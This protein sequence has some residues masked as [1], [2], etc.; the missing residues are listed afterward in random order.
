MKKKIIITFAILSFL[1]PLFSIAQIPSD[2]LSIWL[3]SDSG[4]V[5]NNSNVLQWNDQSGNGRNAISTLGYPQFVANEICGNPVIRFDGSSHGMTTP[6][7]ETFSDKRGCIF[8]VGK[9]NGAGNGAAGYGTFVSTWVGSGVAWQF[10]SNINTYSWYDGVGGSVTPITA[11]PPNELGIITLNRRYDDTLLFYKSGVLVQKKII[12]NNQPTINEVKI[13]YSGSFEV[14][15][16]DIAEIIIYNK[17]LSDSEVYQVNTYL[18]NK[19]CL[20]GNIPQ[21][22]ANNQSNCGPSS[23]DLTASGATHYKWYSDLLSTVPIDTNA[24][25]TTPLLTVSDTFYVAN[26]N[27]TLESMRIMVIATIHPLPEVAFSLDPNTICL[28][29]EAFTLTGGTPIGGT[30][31]GVGVIADTF[32]PSIASVGVHDIIY[33]FTD[34]YDCTNS[35]TTQIHINICNDLE[36]VQYNQPLILYPNPT[37]NQLTIETELNTK[38]KFDIVNIMGQIVYT[39]TIEKTTTIDL[40]QFPNG[41]Y[42]VKIESEKLNIVQKFI[43]Q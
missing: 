7:F 15:N 11:S 42:M 19:Y 9:V 14:L 31:S 32:D 35:D 4:L 41:I 43:K 28:T 27:D 38:Q 23:F 22:T 6:A 12:A 2:S 40:S 3:R 24:I 21:P 37:Q 16:G 29:T 33:S 10:V 30:Y 20:N 18:A 39:S 26:Y 25:Y 13:G 36:S 1:T 5:L 17:S 8:V 34:E